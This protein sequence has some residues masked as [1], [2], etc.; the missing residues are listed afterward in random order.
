MSKNFIKSL[1]LM[2]VAGLTFIAC[3]QSDEPTTAMTEQIDA[4][5]YYHY[6]MVL[7][8]SEPNFDSGATTRAVTY[9]DWTNGAKL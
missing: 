9:T 5:G 6:Q 3:S 8:C 7:N 4:D 1:G 2:I